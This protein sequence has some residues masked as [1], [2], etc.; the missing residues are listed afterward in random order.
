MFRDHWSSRIQS[1]L[2][3]LV[4][5]WYWRLLIEISTTRSDSAL[6]S[7]GYNRQEKWL[8]MNY[9]GGQKGTRPPNRS[10][11]PVPQT[12]F[13]GVFHHSSLRKNA[14]DESPRTRFSRCRRGN[15]WSARNG[16]IRVI[17]CRK[18]SRNRKPI[19]S[20]KHL[21]I[22]IRSISGCCLSIS[23]GHEK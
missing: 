10:L 16:H 8:D 18:T 4:N 11:F 20:L 17:K 19:T 9:F 2:V 6:Y 23:L 21:S 7:V 3:I 13:L 5:V 12:Y 1:Y 22:D 15:P 14:P